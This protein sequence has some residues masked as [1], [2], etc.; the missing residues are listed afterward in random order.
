MTMVACQ[1]PPSVTTADGETRLV[2]KVW[3]DGAWDCPFCGSPNDPSEKF[4]QERGWPGPCGNPAC[5]VGGCGDPEHVAEIRL[6]QQQDA[7]RASQRAWLHRWQEDDR[8][9]RDQARRAAVDAF[10]LEA[11]E[12]GY[13]AEC[14]GRSTSWGLWLDRAKKVRHRSPENCP[15]VRRRKA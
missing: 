2:V 14:W 5:L 7:E 1:P 15:S 13:C 4:Y 6:R 10:T 9:K 3:P 12:H 11:Q 8:V